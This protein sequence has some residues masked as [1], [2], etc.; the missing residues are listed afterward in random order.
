MVRAKT[1]Q[2]SKKEG[3]IMAR[4]PNVFYDAKKMDDII[5]E[6]DGD[7]YSGTNVGTIIMGKGNTY[8]FNCLKRNM[9][10]ED[11]LR[12]VCKFY[13]LRA[14]D[15]I[16][17]EPINVEEPESVEET[18]K[19]V[20][21]DTVLEDSADTPNG[22]STES[23]DPVESS[24]SAEPIKVIAE[25]PEIN[26][27]PVVDLLITQNKLLNDQIAYQKSTNYILEQIEN[28]LIKIKGLDEDILKL[29][30][31]RERKFQNKSNQR[32]IG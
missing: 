27:G 20:P 18:V 16:L 19:P 4:K 15:Y 22:V 21:S 3:V 2:Y 26:L 5:R 11:A 10:S 6:I 31:E 32:R 1:N 29:L 24:K 8:Y 13:K 12:R 17:P 28:R 9:I 7:R 23:V 14:K 30:Q 25:L